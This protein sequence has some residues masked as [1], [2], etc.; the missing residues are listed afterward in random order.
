MYNLFYT[1][2]MDWADAYKL[3]GA[4]GSVALALV[5]LYKV[6]GA[7]INKRAISDCCGKRGSLGIGIQAMESDKPEKD[8]ENP[9]ARPEVDV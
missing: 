9:V 2:K 4:G 8:K 5:I 1:N 7:I 6:G 3:S